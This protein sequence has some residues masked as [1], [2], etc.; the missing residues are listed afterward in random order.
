MPCRQLSRRLIRAD[1]LGSVEQL[2]ASICAASGHIIPPNLVRDV[3]A[4]RLDLAILL[5]ILGGFLVIDLPDTGQGLQPARPDEL[6]PAME[7]GRI[8][9]PKVPRHP[10]T[11]IAR[12]RKE[13][14][15][16]PPRSASALL[17]LR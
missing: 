16:R 9:R 3:S 13:L 10:V 5:L 1:L 11:F 15:R 7:H 12:C 14:R 8:F 2:R 17:A 4:R 6:A